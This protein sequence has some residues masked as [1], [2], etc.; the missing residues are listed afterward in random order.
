MLM[1]RTGALLAAG[2]AM[3]LLSASAHAL[4]VTYQELSLPVDTGVAATNQSSDFTLAGTAALTGA[5]SEGLAR[6][7]WT[8]DFDADEEGR[9]FLYVPGGE[10]NSITY[11]VGFSA[12]GGSL[13]WGSPDDWNT[14]T[15]YDGDDN[16]GEIVPGSSAFD[17][18][19]AGQSSN[20]G[21]F[22]VSFSGIEFDRAVF[23]SE[24]NSLEFSNFSA[25]P[26]PA[27]AL[28]FLSGLVA[29]FAVGW[30][31]SQSQTGSQSFA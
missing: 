1:R 2:L 23:T 30:R 13:I 12:T 15:F 22:L 29:L 31:R 4:G 14:L 8:G 28:L 3:G 6:N 7:P 17:V 9:N 18:L 5:G 26:I 16:V 24:K 20:N 27:A 10:G 25:V 19:T 21:T 11:N